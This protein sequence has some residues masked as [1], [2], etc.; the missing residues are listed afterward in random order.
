M[1]LMQMLCQKMIQG[2]LNNMP[3]MQQVNQFLTGKTPQQQM[4]TL[5]NLAKSK[6]IDVNAKIFSENDLQMLGLKNRQ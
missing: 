5:F 2:K 1:S 3:E 4:E 6:G